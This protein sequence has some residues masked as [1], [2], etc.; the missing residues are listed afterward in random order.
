MLDKLMFQKILILTTFLVVLTACGDDSDDSVSDQNPT[1]SELTDQP[2]VDPAPTPEENPTPTPGE[3]PVPT[4]GEN[5]A[6]TPGENPVPTPGENPVPTP[7][8]NPAPT[9]GE[10]PAPTPTVDH[11]PAAVGDSL[12]L[13]KNTS[14]NIDV[15]ANDSGLQDAPIVVSVYTDPE[16][17]EASV[18]VD[19]TLKYEPNTD[20]I[21]SDRF[22]YKVTDNDNDMTIA[23][24]AIQVDCTG[25][26][27]PVPAVILKLSWD[28]NTDQVNGYRV[29]SGS[30]KATADTLISGD[31]T[32]TTATFNAAKDL[33]LSTGDS[34]CF[35]LKAFNNVGESGFSAGVCTT[36]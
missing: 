7:G 3:N 9:P 33:S 34:V 16:N 31:I 12:T 36:I 1:D 25:V 15:L 20:F 30:T 2:V 27:C 10:N 13:E 29:Y 14:K 22:S 11:F 28:A 5:P 32:A 21:G 17:G 8:E 23:T 24:V 6:P 26:D 35:R 19:G 18:N 4:P